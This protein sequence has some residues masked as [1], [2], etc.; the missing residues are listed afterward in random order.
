MVLAL[1]RQFAKNHPNHAQLIDIY[2]L[3]A[4]ALAKSGAA[5]KAQQ[6]LQQLLARYP[7]HTKTA[8]IRHTLNLLQ[9]QE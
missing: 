3:A 1:T 7:D 9:N 6:L 5:D 2:I 8:Q 4:R